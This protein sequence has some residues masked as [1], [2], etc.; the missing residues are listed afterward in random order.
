MWVF[1]RDL[2]GGGKIPAL[3]T[4]IQTEFLQQIQLNI[5]FLKNLF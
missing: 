2:E 3:H 4:T 1:E 5:R